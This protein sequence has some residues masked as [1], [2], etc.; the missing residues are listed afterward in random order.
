VIDQSILCLWERRHPAGISFEI[1][2]GTQGTTG[3][4]GTERTGSPQRSAHNPE[5][6]EKSGEH[7][8]SIEAM[9]QDTPPEIFMNN[10]AKIQN[11]EEILQN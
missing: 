3:T 11:L 6:R 4:E 8:A 7:P 1:K 9:I 5:K 2:T 10:G